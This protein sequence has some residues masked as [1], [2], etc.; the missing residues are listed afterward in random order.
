MLPR[1]LN[2]VVSQSLQDWHLIVVNDGGDPATVERVLAE[3]EGALGG[4]ITLIHHPETM[5]MEAAS[6]RA[7]EAAQGDYVVV[8]D[9][10]DTW[11]PAFLEKTVGFLSAS[12]N[13]AYIGVVTDCQIVWERILGGQIICEERAPFPSSGRNIELRRVLAGNSFPP[14]SLLLRRAAVLQVGAFN[15]DMPVLGDWEFNLRALAL[16]DFGFITETLAYYHQ[17]RDSSDPVYG[18]SVIAGTADHQRYDVLLRNSVIRLALRDNPAL[19]GVLQPL[20]HAMQEQTEAFNQLRKTMDERVNDLRIRLDRVEEHL[21][22]IRM[23]STWQRKMLD[24]VRFV[25]TSLMP[26]RRLLANLFG[27]QVP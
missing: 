4:R 24:P 12:A 15:I 25:W 19:I 11:H 20:L 23:V 10:D 9:D 5:G 6:N 13:A 22:E 2:S 14:I 16:G 17:R 21:D 1:A 8:H 18:N 27:R 26:A 7:L 3:H